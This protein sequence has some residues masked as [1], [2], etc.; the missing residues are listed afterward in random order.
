MVTAKPE[1]HYVVERF[2]SFDVHPTVDGYQIRDQ[3]VQL[4]DAFIATTT[5]QLP[6]EQDFEA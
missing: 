4:T 5:A 6:G 1:S 3:L 2:I